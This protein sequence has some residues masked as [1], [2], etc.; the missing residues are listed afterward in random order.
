ML[1]FKIDASDISFVQNIGSGRIVSAEASDLM[2]LKTKGKITAVIE[3]TGEVSAEFSV[4]VL[5]CTYGV[6]QVPAEAAVINPGQTVTMH[7]SVMAFVTVD[8]GTKSF[9]CEGEGVQQ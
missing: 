9:M 4:S 8:E 2:A 6:H 7:F 5:K 1:T 3:N